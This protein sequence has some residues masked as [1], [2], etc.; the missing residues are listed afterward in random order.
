M[1]YK[2]KSKKRLHLQPQFNYTIVGHSSGHKISNCSSPLDDFTT[3][4]SQPT[5][6]HHTPY[7]C[8]FCLW[9]SLYRSRNAQPCASLQ[10]L[11]TTRSVVSSGTQIPSHTYEALAKLQSRCVTISSRITDGYPAPCPNCSLVFEPLSPCE[12]LQTSM[13]VARE[14]SKSIGK[15][16]QQEAIVDKQQWPSAPFR[17]DQVTAE[18][19]RCYSEVSEVV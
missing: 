6:P 14:G 9:L 13:S 8:S 4:S 11:T 1:I 18:L 3:G 7:S 5:C 2:I 16:S 15:K 10:W 19:G 12:V 17:A